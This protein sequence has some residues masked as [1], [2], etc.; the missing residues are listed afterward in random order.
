M[1]K[2]VSSKIEAAFLLNISVVERF[3]TKVN[4]NSMVI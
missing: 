3:E 2:A 4:F 1:C